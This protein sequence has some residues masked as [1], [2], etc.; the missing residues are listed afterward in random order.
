MDGRRLKPSTKKAYLIALTVFTVSV[1]LLAGFS[2][3]SG[4]P[5]YPEMIVRL[6]LV[7][8]MVFI[9]TV[10]RIYVSGSRWAYGKPYILLNIMFAPLYFGAAV[11]GLFTDNRYVT[12]NDLL[13]CA[14]IFI[15]VFTIAQILSYLI[16]K[17]GT[18]KMND[19]LN[20]FQKEHQEDVYEEEM[21]DNN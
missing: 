14:L 11:I 12:L 19:A 7:D 6:F 5:V 15:V 8:I 3:V 16:K 17:A 20:E 21:V 13:L 2:A 4:E 1:V 10:I 9:L 18:D